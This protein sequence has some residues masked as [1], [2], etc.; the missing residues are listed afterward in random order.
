MA[1]NQ[2]EGGIP[3]QLLQEEGLAS[4]DDAAWSNYWDALQRSHAFGPRV[5][6]HYSIPSCPVPPP[7]SDRPASSSRLQ[8]S[9]RQRERARLI[10]QRLLR[11]LI[12]STPEQQMM[13]VADGITLNT[14]PRDP[15]GPDLS[16]LPPPMS[17]YC[18]DEEQPALPPPIAAVLDGGHLTDQIYLVDNRALENG[19]SAAEETPLRTAVADFTTAVI[20]QPLLEEVLMNQWTGSL[21]P[22]PGAVMCGA[23]ARFREWRR[24]HAIQRAIGT[25][26]QEALIDLKIDPR[27]RRP[28]EFVRRH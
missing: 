16:V 22:S 17:S 7:S 19:L 15:C 13:F 9:R 28:G 5:H 3:P 21:D 11:A 12:A 14:A 24:Q 26:A 27:Y 8:W 2:E 10:R 23:P 18:V 1:T 20:V 6:P 25:T 4:M